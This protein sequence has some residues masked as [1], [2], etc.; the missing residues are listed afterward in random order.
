MLFAKERIKMKLTVRKYVLGAALA[1][2]PALMAAQSR[3]NTPNGQNPPNGQGQPS[4]TT[5]GQSTPNGSPNSASTSGNTQNAMSSDQKFVREAAQGG[6]A[7]VE[8]GK[9]AAEKGSSQDVKKFGQR[10]VDDHTKANDELK[11]IASQKG[12][13][14]PDKMSSKDEKLK[15]R[16]SKMSG[17][18]FD[19]AYMTEMVKDHKKD[20]ADFTKE[21]DKGKDSEVKQFASKTLPTLKEH[22]Q[23]A[24]QTAPSSQKSEAGSGTGPSSK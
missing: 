8:L 19:R 24:Q 4:G 17:D 21:S 9:M 20:V 16:L 10:M 7:E 3:P 5:M 23:Q 18:Q 11:Q 14:V 13:D 12:I 22:L 6:L 2:L 1:S 15:G